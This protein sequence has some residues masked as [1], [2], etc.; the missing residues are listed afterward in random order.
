[1]AGSAIKCDSFAGQANT[2]C[3]QITRRSES[4][5]FSVADRHRRSV[6]HVR[7]RL[8]S[9]FVARSDLRPKLR[10]ARPILAVRS[11][12]ARQSVRTGCIG[13]VARHAPHRSRV[14][15]DGATSESHSAAGGSTG[16]LQPNRVVGS[17]DGSNVAANCG[18]AADSIGTSKPG[19]L[20]SH[21]ST[22]LIKFW[23]DTF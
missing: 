9:T 6:R 19:S 2:V 8:V 15:A 14:R 10:T 18:Q 12:F 4:G 20:N 11:P 7:A 21:V 3:R 5:C 22:W 13:A 23:F 17:T 1:M 16:Q